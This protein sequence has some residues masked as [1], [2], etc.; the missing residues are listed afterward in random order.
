MNE[1]IANKVAPRLQRS[2]S[3]FRK[4]DAA[5]ESAPRWHMMF[6]FQASIQ[7]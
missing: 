3:W 5:D 7:F 6:K 1:Q 2:R 4:I